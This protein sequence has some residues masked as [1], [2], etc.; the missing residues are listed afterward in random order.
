M[1][2]WYIQTEKA[3]RDNF[4]MEKDMEMV[5]IGAMKV[6]LSTKV[7]GIETNLFPD[8]HILIICDIFTIK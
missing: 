6:Q 3:T 1:V 4:A 8:L 5:Y 7:N 2:W